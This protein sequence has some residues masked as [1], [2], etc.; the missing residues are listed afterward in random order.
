MKSEWTDE[1]AMG[2]LG[3]GLLMA[4]YYGRTEL[5]GMIVS[6]MAGAIGIHLKRESRRDEHQ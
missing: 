6:A 2:A 5:A 4:I 1:L 3:I